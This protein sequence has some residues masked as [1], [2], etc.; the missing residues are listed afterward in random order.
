MSKGVRKLEWMNYIC[1]RNVTEKNI[2][3]PWKSPTSKAELKQLKREGLEYSAED[4]SGIPTTTRNFTPRNQG[5]AKSRTGAK[6]ADYQVD[7][8]V[9]GIQ[10]GPTTSTRGGLPE[11]PI[12]YTREHLIR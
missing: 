10:R 11:Y 6:S 3:Y 7:L 8:D 12:S 1:H 5:I 2:F 4:G 9:S